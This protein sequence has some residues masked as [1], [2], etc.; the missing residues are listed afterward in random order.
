MN[1][2]KGGRDMKEKYEAMDMAIIAFDIED[3]IITSNEEIS[4]GDED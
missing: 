1:L 2:W 3:T 4:D